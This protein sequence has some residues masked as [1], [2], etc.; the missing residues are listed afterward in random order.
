MLPLVSRRTL[1]TK[2]YVVHDRLLDGIIDDALA[3]AV[4]RLNN[5]LPN[6]VSIDVTSVDLGPVR[7]ELRSAVSDRLSEIS[8]PLNPNDPIINAILARYAERLNGLF[9]VEALQLDHYIWRS[10]D[11]A[12][13]RA[14]HAAYDDHVFAWS[15]PPD[16][17]HPGQAWNCRCTAEPI[18]D[19]EHL[20]E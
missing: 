6:G 16:G 10:Q 19:A 15:D 5:Y 17:G 7:D 4:A 3:A 12:R 2:F 13:V 1:E 18:I 9:Q 14:A 8:V 20:P 11:D